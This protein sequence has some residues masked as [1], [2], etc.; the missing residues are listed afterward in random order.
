MKM[1]ENVDK[2]LLK[3]LTY[4]RRAQLA[5]SVFPLTLTQHLKNPYCLFLFFSEEF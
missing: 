5:P 1:K 3:Y 4:V 2:H